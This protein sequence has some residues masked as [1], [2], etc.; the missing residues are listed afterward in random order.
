[1]STNADVIIVGAG[2]SGLAAA[3]ALS[4]SGHS[5]VILEARD[6]IGGRGLTLHDPVCQA[7]IE[8]GAE[9]IHGRPASIWKAL[10]KRDV[11]IAEVAG[12]S[13]C[14]EEGSPFTGRFFADAQDKLET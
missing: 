14:V 4:K 11:N 1:M 12:C 2:V 3:A 8:V 5:V 10:Q 9:F 7:P 13:Q 6:W